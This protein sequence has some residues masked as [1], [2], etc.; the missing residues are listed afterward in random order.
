MQG[1]C[2]LQRAPLHVFTAYTVMTSFLYIRTRTNNY[3]NRELRYEPK[4]ITNIR[5][6]HTYFSIQVVGCDYSSSSF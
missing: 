6:F 5:H 1:T 2:K 3:R 4:R